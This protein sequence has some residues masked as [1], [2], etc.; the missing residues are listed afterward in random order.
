MWCGRALAASLLAL[1]AAPSFAAPQSFALGS[2]GRTL[3]IRALTDT[4]LAFELTTSTPTPRNRPWPA[5]P[6]VYKRRYPGARRF[7]RSASGFSTE[8]LEV[9]VDPA[10]CVTVSLR[11]AGELLSRLCPLRAE[12]APGGLTIASTGTL[13]AYGL[14]EKFFRP[15]QPNG[16][17]MGKVRGSANP[18]GN[19]LLPFEGGYVEN[20]QFPVLYAARAAK[21]DFALFVD[22]AR[23]Q[24]WTLGE[25]LWK[26][27]VQAEPLRFYF[28]SGEGLPALREQY[29]E[30]VG[31][32]PVPA[33]KMFGLW[34][35]EFGYRNW[36]EIE[37]KLK[38][39]REDGFPVDGFVIDIYWFGPFTQGGPNFFGH[40]DW[41]K[42]KFPDP[43][44][45][46][47]DLEKR[48]I[49]V[50]L[51]EDSY[52]N[53][54][55]PEFETLA[56]KG[57]LVRSSKD[58]QPLDLKS[59]W[60]EGGMIDVTKL[61]GERAWHDWKRQP[62]IDDGVTVHW[63]DLD[64]PE[65]YGDDALYAGGP[66]LEG[67]SEADVHNLY[68]LL[69]ARGIADGYARHRVKERPF[70]LSRSGASG[71]ARYGTALWSGDIGSN[72]PSLAAHANAQ[73][74][75]SFSGQDYFGCDVGGFHREALQGSMDEVYTRWLG[76]SALFDV[77]LRP[78]TDNGS[79]HNET[80]PD[81]VG[82]VDA[83]RANVRLRY[84]LIPYYYSLAYRAHLSGEPV[85]PPLAYYYEDEPD[86][87]ALGD[88][89]LIGRD[90]LAAPSFRLGETSR[91]VYLPAGD[92]V[93]WRSLVVHH[94]AGQWFS[95]VP[96]MQEGAYAV[97]LFA[98][99]G[100]II[101]MMR[102][103]DQTRDAFNSARDGAARDG[104]TLR[105]FPSPEPTQFT[106]YEDDG[107]TVDYLRGR[108][109]ATTVS[110][111]AGKD[112]VRVT[113][114][115]ARGSYPGAPAKRSVRV[116]LFSD[117]PIASVTAD[118][119]DV[120][121]KMDGGLT[122]VELPDQRASRRLELLFQPR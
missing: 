122:V 60:G 14:G 9:A 28:F 50:A 37:D 81:R 36:D 97:P 43:I 65:T 113:I 33:R 55:L 3:T 107:R 45:H 68:A 110:Q 69:Y 96:L 31:R 54:G 78:H 48:G 72:L 106:V 29:M 8:A 121:W 89:K 47:T 93:D 26:D 92:W 46:L 58:G 76:Y 30:L 7:Q 56:A 21:R 73:M 16:D 83:N 100:A 2:G 27:E 13:A 11:S 94:S 82:D 18:Y 85:F 24:T 70:I 117:R 35:S 57:Y 61:A 79:K 40:M 41:D 19:A 120:P 1:L 22:S 52:V 108:L 80:A 20:A 115:K 34:V 90:L 4:A 44:G 67:D 74:H 66:G 99:A 51:S 59:W 10:L 105:V 119:K 77:P 32:P 114:E 103:D 84:E 17:W 53:R 112:G 104:L 25:P 118:G 111:Q 71:I 109:R 64:E 75:L 49:S 39:L 88:E 6:M 102:V 63:T 95:D 91:N 5:T 23:R 12:G 62:L 38:G 87:L 101:P 116:E 15:G 98:R 86:A 42:S